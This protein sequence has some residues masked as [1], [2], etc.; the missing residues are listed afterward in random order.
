MKS[1]TSVIFKNSRR[2]IVVANKKENVLGVLAFLIVFGAIGTAMAMFSYSIT[3]QLQEINQAYTF[4]NI[5][6]LMNFFILFAKSV[7][8]SLNV[9]Y[10]SKDLKV[11]LRMPIKPKDILHSKMLNMIVSE[12]EMEIIMLAIPMIVYGILTKASM[13]FYVYMVAILLIL[14]IIPILLTSLVIAIIMRFTN[15]IKNKS[16]V[17]YITL[18]LTTLIVSMITSSFN[19]QQNFSVSAI[20]NVILKANGVAETIADYFILIKPIMNTLLNYDNISG[21]QNLIIYIIENIICYFVIIWFMSK[22]YL[23]GAIGATINSKKNTKKEDS[24]L[25]LKDFKKKNKYRTYILK[26]FKTILRTPIFFIECI[27]VPTLYPFFIFFTIIAMTEFAS[28][29]GLDLWEKIRNIAVEPLGL[30]IT[31]GVGQIFYMMNFTSIISISRESKNAMI[32][33]YIPIDLKKQFNLKIYLGTLFNMVAAVLVTV[34][35]YMCTKNLA[36]SIVI[37]IMLYLIN[38]M[39]EK[40]KIL[41]DLNKPQLVWDTEYT[42]MKQNTNVMYELFYSLIVAGIF[43]LI[44]LVFA[45]SNMFLFALFIVL[46]IIN[47]GYNIY[48]KKNITK[49][50]KKVY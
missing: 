46:A 35:Y 39:G 5:L 38:R 25:T 2:R 17:I 6:L 11:L 9:L 45:D 32:T 44:S 33:K 29:V 18:I 15:K 40:L 28:F 24:E 49:L 27:I 16:K 12:Y 21:L 3:T 34:F 26:E 41:I 1:L 8:E 31:L 23:K 20:K 50:F 4:T 7:F 43:Y 30:A 36:V 22:I 19:S 14:P 48:I 47:I 42:M 13:L 10:F 37:F